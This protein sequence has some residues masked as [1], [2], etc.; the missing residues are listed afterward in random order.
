MLTTGL[1]ALSL[2]LGK[3]PGPLPSLGAGTPPANGLRQSVYWENA[4]ALQSASSI[5]PVTVAAGAAATDLLG[6]GNIADARAHN[7]VS[8]AELRG[9]LDIAVP[10]AYR[11][12]LSSDDGS[13]M[14][15]DDER[16]IVNDGNHALRAVESRA[17]DLAAGAY[18]LRVQWYN[19][20]GGG[21]L[22]LEWQ[23]PG[24][25]AYAPVP[26]ARFTPA[27]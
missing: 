21:S 18:P 24:A 27:S 2:V 6:S 3:R 9:S 16:I 13:V 5:K 7:A 20:A 12:R 15:L 14:W 17:F 23:T 26:A 10:G 25:A 4:G 22:L 8:M 11:F 1:Q 19:A